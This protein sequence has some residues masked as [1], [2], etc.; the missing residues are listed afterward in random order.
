MERR[1]GE[2]HVVRLEKNGRGWWARLVGDGDFYCLPANFSH[3]FAISTERKV[4]ANAIIFILGIVFLYVLFFQS[5]ISSMIDVVAE[6]TAAAALLTTS[7]LTITFSVYHNTSS[8][9][10]HSVCLIPAEL[11]GV[12]KEEIINVVAHEYDWVAAHMIFES[13]MDVLKDVRCVD[14]QQN[15]YTVLIRSIGWAVARLFTTGHL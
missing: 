2:G 15:M 1:V 7:P 3:T 8:L 13:G 5:I 14:V 12:D 11:Y 6:A 9:V 4:V 10:F